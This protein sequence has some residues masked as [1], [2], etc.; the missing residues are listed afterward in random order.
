MLGCT[1]WA[2]SGSGSNVECRISGRGRDS[3]CM[4]YEDIQIR[5]HKAQSPALEP[6]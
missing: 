2:Q 6:G 1:C 5:S 4:V 3:L